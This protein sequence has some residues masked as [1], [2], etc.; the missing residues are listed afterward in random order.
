MFYISIHYVYISVHHCTSFYFSNYGV[1]IVRVSN[2]SKNSKVFLNYKFNIFL[3][4]S[5]TF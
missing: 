5:F 2:L 4:G 1:T 3:Y